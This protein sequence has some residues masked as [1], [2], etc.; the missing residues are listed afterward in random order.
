[1]S[2]ARGEKGQV[3]A[4]VGKT[5]RRQRR[6]AVLKLKRYLCECSI[7]ENAA[8][9]RSGVLLR[10]RGS[11]ASVFL[12]L[13]SSVGPVLCPMPQGG[14]NIQVKKCAARF[15]CSS[16]RC[17]SL[18]LHTLY[19]REGEERASAFTYALKTNPQHHHSKH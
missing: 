1:M 15:L 12:L 5:I 6:T 13:N 19:Q 16:A 7:N 11:Q 4:R 18:A 9:Y 8:G 17:V 14:L 2:G 3:Q 10:G